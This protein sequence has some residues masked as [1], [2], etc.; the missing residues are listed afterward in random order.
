MILAGL[1]CSMICR[2]KGKATLRK[3]VHNNS[4]ISKAA[5]TTGPPCMGFLH[6]FDLQLDVVIYIGTSSVFSA[7]S[8]GGIIREY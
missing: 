3:I 4:D 5:T 6:L 2:A 8:W 1:A 7:P